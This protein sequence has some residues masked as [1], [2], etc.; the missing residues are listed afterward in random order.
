MLTICDG[1]D[2]PLRA[3]PFPAVPSYSII[4]LSF[5]I[6]RPALEFAPCVKPI[7][8]SLLPHYS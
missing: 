8:Q 7:C 6:Q 1:R 3:K 2:H 4:A 5:A